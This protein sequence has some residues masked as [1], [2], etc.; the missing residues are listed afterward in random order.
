MTDITFEFSRPIAAD[1]I[2]PSGMDQ[3]LEAKPAERAAL[4]KRFDLVELK[5]LK[6]QL[7]LTPGRD[8][9]VTVK[10]TLFADIVQSCV[11]TL[12]PVATHFELPVDTVFIPA[13]LNKKGA[14]SPDPEDVDE[15]FEI[16]SGGK[17]DLGEMVAQH[18][19]I[20]IDPYPRKAGV[21]LGAVEFGAKAEKP[22][23]MAVLADLAK[24]PKK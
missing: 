12:E 1:H 6:A 13:A 18:L 17:I 2:P 22:K 23:A 20:N 11:V 10:G 14:G 19:G 9:M 24:K 15:E 4:A 5:R 8:Y 7:T 21:M 16:Y 3:N